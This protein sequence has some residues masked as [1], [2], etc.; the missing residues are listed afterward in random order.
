M[1]DQVIVMGP[2]YWAI[3]IFG[4]VFFG[5]IAAFLII[6]ALTRL[7]RYVGWKLLAAWIAFF[8]IIAL[9]GLSMFTSC[10]PLRAFMAR[11]Y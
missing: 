11:G 3:V 1:S 8:A 4:I 7:A 6:Y 9:I 2:G 10:E 5:G